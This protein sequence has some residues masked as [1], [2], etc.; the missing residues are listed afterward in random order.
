M[1]DRKKIRLFQKIKTYSND[2]FWLQMNAWHSRAYFLSQKHMQEAMECMPG[3]TK[4]QI[5]AV[6][7]KAEQIRIEWDKLPNI[8]MDLT[9]DLL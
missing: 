5:E 6:I 3:I 9:E 1:E 8:D 4:S 2:R 7:K